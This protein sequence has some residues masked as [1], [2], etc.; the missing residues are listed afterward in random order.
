LLYS[1]TALLIVPSQIQTAHETLKDPSLRRC[2][3]AHLERPNHSNHSTASHTHRYHDFFDEDTDGNSHFF[4]ELFSQAA[5]ARS[6]ST[7]GG[8]PR[9]FPG[10]PN[11]FFGE[12]YTAYEEME[13]EFREQEQQY[14]QHQEE[15]IK[16]ARRVAAE[17]AAEKKRRDDEKK[18][19]E[20]IKKSE[21]ELKEREAKERQE[22]RWA[23]TGV[24]SESDKLKTCY[25]DAFWAK[26]PQK[27]KFKCEKCAQ[28]RGLISFKCPHCGLLVCQLCN[29]MLRKRPT[30]D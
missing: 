2:Y 1:E 8:S 24:K 9:G 12:L 6:F 30:V 23:N 4:E 11:F 27:R 25:H 26:V 10:F 15:V 17:K 18:R 13:R 20:Q 29:V 3:D 7:S 22:L 5:R 14:R 21:K 16:E 28:K 19:E